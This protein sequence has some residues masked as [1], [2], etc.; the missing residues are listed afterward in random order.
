MH[1]SVVDVRM[2]SMWY[3][4]GGNSKPEARRSPSGPVRISDIDPRRR[5]HHLLQPV[6]PH[7]HKFLPRTGPLSNWSHY[8]YQT[9]IRAVRRII[10]P[11]RLSAPPALCVF[12]LIIC[13]LDESCLDGQNQSLVE[14]RSC[15]LL[16]LALIEAFLHLLSRLYVLRETACERLTSNISRFIL[17]E[18]S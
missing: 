7:T 14:G 13:Y 10:H 8:R 3:M 17:K 2:Y 11:Q 5:P 9:S 1:V 18:T 6:I 15:D 4:D 12:M 16:K